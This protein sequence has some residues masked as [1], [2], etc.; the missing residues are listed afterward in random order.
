MIITIHLA[1]TIWQSYRV[2]RCSDKV[3]CLL[4]HDMVSGY[5][6]ISST[7]IF[8]ALFPSRC[9]TT[10][11]FMMHIIF[12]L[13]EG[14]NSWIYI[15]WSKWSKKQMKLNQ[16]IKN[17]N[18][19]EWNAIWSEIIRVISRPKLHNPKFNSHNL[20]AWIQELLEQQKLPNLPNNSLFVFHFP[21][22]WLFSLKKP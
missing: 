1:T 17:G 3:F 20:I 5:L 21:P 10:S 9:G 6:N 7:I 13:H 18:W 11:V 16:L 8:P 2:K 4:K 12:Q 19:T 14:N 22:V 15:T